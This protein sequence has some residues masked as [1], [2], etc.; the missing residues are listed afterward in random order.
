M[1]SSIRHFTSQ[2]DKK[3]SQPIFFSKPIFFLHTIFFFLNGQCRLDPVMSS[4]PS[5]PR[6]ILFLYHGEASDVLNSLQIAAHAVW[7]VALVLLITKILWSPLDKATTYGKLLFSRSARQ[8][9]PEAIKTGQAASTASPSESATTGNKATTGQYQWM[10]MRFAFTSSYV[11]G[12]LWVLVLAVSFV[13][14]ILVL[15][16]TAPFPAS[17]SCNY[18]PLAAN[19]TLNSTLI[20]TGATHDTAT[21]VIPQ[22]SDFGDD[23]KSESPLPTD[24]ALLPENGN[25]TIPYFSSDVWYQSLCSMAHQIAQMDDSWSEVLSPQMAVKLAMYVLNNSSLFRALVLSVL[26]V[27]H[28]SRRSLECL[29][30]HVFSPR[31]ISFHNLILMWAYYAVAP[32]VLLIDLFAQSVQGAMHPGRYGYDMISVILICVGAEIFLLGSILQFSAHLTLAAG[33]SPEATK[34]KYDYF[35]PKG[36][37]FDYISC[38]HYLSELIIYAAYTLVAGATQGSL[39]VLAFVALTMGSQ[40]AKTH[41]WYRANFTSRQLGDRKAFIPFVW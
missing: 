27:I 21:P 13:G 23:E 9:Q 30:L 16:E 2:A 25:L 26:M 22:G 17:N 28:L 7:G 6:L 12:W 24:P 8:A 40:A 18:L 19:R 1:R 37:L 20:A 32:F 4:L 31:P 38:P 34:S 11:L 39:L 33:R 29:F 36:G 3:K 41:E 35:V 5:L 15:H 10:N 14:L